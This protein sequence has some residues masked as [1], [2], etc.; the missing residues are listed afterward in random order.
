MDATMIGRTFTAQHHLFALAGILLLAVILRMFFFQGFVESDPYCYAELANDLAHGKLLLNSYDGALIFPLRIGFYGPAAFFIKLFGL[1]EDSVII[2][3]FLV[4]IAGCVLAYILGRTLFGPTAGLIAAGLLAILP[5]DVAMASTLFPDPVAAFWT[6]LGIALLILDPVKDG[7]RRSL[8]YAALAGMCLGISWLNKETVVYAA[9][10]VLIL[11]LTQK[12]PFR[13]L[14]CIAAVILLFLFSE[15]AFYRATTGDWLFHF[16]IVPKNYQQN[17]V[18]FFDQSSP[19]FGWKPGGYVHALLRRILV[20]GPKEEL[21]AFCMLPT[22]ALIAA[23]WGSLGRDRRFVMLGVW[24]LLQLLAFDLASSSLTAYKPLPLV[25][26]R[27]LYPL[28]LPSVLLCSGFISMLFLRTGG[29]QFVTH[30]RLWATAV[31]TVILASVALPLTELRPQPLK[32][33]RHIAERVGPSATVY[34]DF[35]TAEFLTFFAQDRI[36]N[37]DELAEAKPI[38]PYEKL[39]V[40]EMRPDSYVVINDRPLDF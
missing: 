40:S 20:S 26:E 10:F 2:V 24:L 5:R 38:I 22:F 27:Y 37:T 33:I 32:M 21:M 31:T 15:A 39:R 1:S 3:P 4:S 16:H 28:L 36:L 13:K 29:A 34:T 35:Y 11:V 14:S 6:N 30:R 17:A 7:S 9:P 23:F 12:S 18:W 19:Y 25:F 8:S